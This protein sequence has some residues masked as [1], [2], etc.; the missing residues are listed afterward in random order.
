MLHTIQT[1]QFIKSDIDRVWKFISSPKNLS[2]ITPTSMGFI[3]ISNEDEAENMYAGQIVEYYVKP[4]L[5]IK[6]YWATEITHVKVNEYFVDEQRV[7]PYKL[8]HHQHF[9]KAVDGGVE[10]TDIV[11]YKTPFGILGRIANAMFIKKQLKTIFDYRFNKL[12]EIFNQ[13]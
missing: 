1:K 3:I 7:G 10:M 12:N 6:M 8:W 4:L 11:H 13:N 9:L 5:G 2:V